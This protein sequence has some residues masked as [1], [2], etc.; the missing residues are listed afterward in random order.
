MIKYLKI[1]YFYCFWL[2]YEGL[3]IKKD[4]VVTW[5][6]DMSLKKVKYPW[7]CPK[8]I[9]L[10]A[11]TH[12]WAFLPQLTDQVPSLGNPQLRNRF[13][14]LGLFVVLVSLLAHPETLMTR[15]GTHFLMSSYCHIRFNSSPCFF[16]QVGLVTHVLCHL[17]T[18]CFA[19][20]D[21]FQIIVKTSIS[22]KC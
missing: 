3:M 8:T 11:H 13:W 16:F 12:P 9:F 4:K 5:N 15:P 14:L 6:V 19:F 21:A 7:K 22:L 1:L 17:P 20:K 2:V 18:D 10:Q